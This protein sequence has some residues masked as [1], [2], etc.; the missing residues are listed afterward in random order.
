MEAVS[1]QRLE[2]FSVAVPVLLRHR[3]ALRVAVSFFAVVVA[4]AAEA[5]RPH[6]GRQNAQVLKGDESGDND[7]GHQT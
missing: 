2:A 1:V 7:D 6:N 5:F 4:I 3:Q